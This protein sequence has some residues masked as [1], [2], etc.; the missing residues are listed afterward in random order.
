MRNGKRQHSGFSLT[1]VLL[2]VGTLAVGMI[3]IG[4]TFVVGIH[5]TTISSERT[6]AAIVADEAFAKIALYGVNLGD[7]NLTFN[8]L[9]PFEA[10]AARAVD[11]NEFAYPSVR[12]PVERQYFWSALCRRLDPNPAGR[13]VE[14]TVFISRRIGSDPRYWLRNSFMPPVLL[15]SPLPRPVPVPVVHH[16]LITG[17]NELQIN[18][19]DPGDL[20]NEVA[21]VNDGLT[22]V[23]NTFGGI[24]QVVERYADRPDI[25][26]LKTPWV[27]AATDWVWVVPPPAGGGRPPC[28]AVYQK[29]IRF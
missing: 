12:T 22:I 23:D 7:P 1:E 16:P 14:V 27:G 26:R 17:F 20:V 28:I 9:T 13:V 2:A 24:Y 19:A 11:P 6:T 5:F 29:E 10:L 3:F 21:F 8:R 4:G 18:D 15:Q 25:I